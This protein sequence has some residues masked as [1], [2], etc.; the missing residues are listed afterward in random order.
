MR[1]KVITGLAV[2]AFLTG[3]GGANDHPA[4]LLG[5]WKSDCKFGVQET[6]TFDSQLTMQT[7]A[8]SDENCTD[9][10]G[11]SIA[12]KADVLYDP[13]L[14]TTESGIEALKTQ[15]TITDV[16]ITP[17]SDR[18]M[19]QYTTA[20]PNQNWVQGQETSIMECERYIE[21]FEFN[22]SSLL[23]INDNNLYSSISNG[24]KDDD[25]YPSDVYFDKA[26]TKQ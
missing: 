1:M 23:Y 12:L 7:E 19:R 15:I 17:Y 2:A 24:P 10:G 25:G 22:Y 6:I 14:K 4:E 9:H 18:A 3:C 8:Y 16:I 13:E 5:A 26:Y 20:C 21:D 11:E